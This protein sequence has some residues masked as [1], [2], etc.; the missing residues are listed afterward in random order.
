[1]RIRVGDV[2]IKHSERAEI[3]QVLDNTYSYKLFNTEGVH[4]YHPVAKP[5][6]HEEVIESGWRLDESIVVSSIL[7]AYED[8]N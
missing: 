3:T 5:P 8:R 7:K 6:T 4:E 2:F 1:M